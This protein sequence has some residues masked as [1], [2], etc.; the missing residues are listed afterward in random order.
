V[1]FTYQ[2]T[3]GES[4]S[5]PASRVRILVA[6]APPPAEP[7]VPGQVAIPFNLSNTPLEQSTAGVPPNVL[8]VA[9]DSFS[10]DY[11]MV[12]PEGPDESLMVLDN[13][14][15]RNRPVAT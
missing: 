10:M 15:V 13:S 1:S 4:F 6:E 5:E 3:D 8:V 2:L 12:V 9:D 11:Q 14:A 7:P